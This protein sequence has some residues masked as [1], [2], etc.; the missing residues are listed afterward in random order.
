M[1]LKHKLLIPFAIPFVILIRLIRPLVKIRFCIMNS[2]RIGGIYEGSWYMACREKNDLP[3]GTFDIFCYVPMNGTHG[4]AFM[5]KMYKRVLNLH[6]GGIFEYVIDKINRKIPGW[7][8]HVVPKRY[9]DMVKDS[10]TK[11]D[12]YQ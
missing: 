3:R 8:G 11:K 1:I 6:C 12:G 9:L 2:S 7:K 5:V 10:E 4:N